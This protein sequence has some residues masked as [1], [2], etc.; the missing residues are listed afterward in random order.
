MRWLP[1][2]LGACEDPGALPADH[3]ELRVVQ[4]TFVDAGRVTPELL[5][6]PASDERVLDTWLWI[7]AARGD[8]ARA[9]P[10][11]LIAHGTEGHPEKFDAF[12]RALASEGVVVAA[13]RFPASAQDSGA[14]S[15]GV[16]DLGEQPADLDVVLAGLLDAVADEGDDLFGMFDPSRVVALGHSLGGATVLGW[17]RFGSSPPLLG[18]ITLSPAVPLTVIFGPYP[19]PSGPP[20]LLAHGTYDPLVGYPVSESLY[21]ELDDPC[22]LLGI[23]GGEHSDPLEDQS[24][25][26]LP[27]RDALERATLGFVRSLAW[28]SPGPLDLA[29]TQLASEGHDV[30]W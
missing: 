13:P 11:L 6:L 25:P 15:L 18:T 4:R 22:W 28:R 24:D 5:D 12:A 2:L 9:R 23:A 16:S 27:T 1:L 10:L 21:A 29:L 30:R 3:D 26:P 20:T 8:A 19:D 17:T 14:A 7:G